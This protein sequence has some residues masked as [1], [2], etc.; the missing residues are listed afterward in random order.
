MRPRFGDALA[1]SVLRPLAEQLIGALDLR[2]GAAACDL[3]CDGGVLT[4]ALAHAVAPIGGVV[5]TDT[6]LDLATDAA[7]LANRHCVVVPRMTDGATVPLDD[8]SCDAVASLLTAVFADHRQLM[9]DA[10]RVLRPNGLAAFLVWDPEDPPPFLTALEAALRAHGIASLF[11]QRVLAPVAVPRSARVRVLRDVCRMATTAH[12][13]AALQDGPLAVELAPLPADTV[14]AVRRDFE[15]ALEP[16]LEADATL[17]IPLR[18]R[19]IT[20]TSQ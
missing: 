12:L 8:R 19:V 14:N 10:P 16:F 4:F 20:V 1:A 5:A 2:P 17:R 13:W 3:L 7:L 9:Q 11:L 6:D 18:A 15:A